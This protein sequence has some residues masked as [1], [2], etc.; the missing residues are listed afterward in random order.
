MNSNT[1]KLGILAA[2]WGLL[3]L[4]GFYQFL[5]YQTKPEDAAAPPSYWPS[6]ATF[7]TYTSGSRLLMVA[8][9]RCP[10]SRASIGELA[11]IMAQ[12]P[13]NVE[14]TVLFYS[15]SDQDANWTKT[16][17]WE[18]A[19]SIPGV[20][21]IADIDG[22]IIKQFNATTSGEV[23]VYD[24]SGNI[25]FWGGITGSRGHS[26]EN[27]GRQA[28]IAALNGETPKFGHTAVF[29]CHLFGNEVSTT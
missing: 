2:I 3:V 5:L 20:Q 24:K 16:D 13:S 22:S 12:T 4:G 6:A 29:G 25:A 9:P 8:H 28:V 26:G 17:I 14:A 11:V 7:S 27:A 19:Q 1:L 21:V 18:G 15:P 23:L 10:C